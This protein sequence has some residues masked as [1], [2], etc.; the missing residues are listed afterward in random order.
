MMGTVSYYTENYILDNAEREF[1]Q[2][3]ERIRNYL[4]YPRGNPFVF[5]NTLKAPPPAN[6][7][8]SIGS[9]SPSPYASYVQFYNENPPNAIQRFLVK[10]IFGINI[11]RF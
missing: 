5:T 8:I 6:I 3:I 7:R 10:K 2:E 9:S 1:K 4:D 11:E